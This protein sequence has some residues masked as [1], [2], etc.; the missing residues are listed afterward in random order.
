[1]IDDND[2][3]GGTSPFWL[4]SVSFSWVLLEKVTQTFFSTKTY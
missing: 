1:M 3:G 4:F 2:C